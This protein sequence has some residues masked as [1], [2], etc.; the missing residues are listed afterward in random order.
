MK[1]LSKLNLDNLKQNRTRTIVTILGVAMSIM[2][3]LT[4]IGI[5][6][7][8]WFTEYDSIR[9]EYGDYHVMFENIP[10]DKVSIL[11]NSKFFNVE[12]YSEPVEAVI[13]KDGERYLYWYG[14]YPVS[15]YTKITADELK[16]DRNHSYNVFL[17]YKDF[18]NTQF[19]DKMQKRALEEADV[20]DVYVRYNSDLQMLEG[21]IPRTSRIA[22]AAFTTLVLGVMVIAA[23]FVIRNSFNISITERVRQ[24]GMLSSVGARPRQIRRMVYMESA[25]IGLIALPIGIGLG[26]LLTFGVVVLFNTLL[27]DIMDA[28]GMELVFFIPWQAIII[29]LIVTAVLIFLSA[30]SPA[31]VAGRYSPL[32]ALRSNQDIKI[33]AR[34][35]RTSKLTRKIWGIGGVIARKNLKRSRQKYRTTV[36]SIV[37]SVSVFIG[38][39]SFM[40]YSH[41]VINL[42][43]NDNGS[44]F[45]IYGN[46]NSVDTNEIASNFNLKEYAAYHYISFETIGDDNRMH[47]SFTVVSRD[48][49]ARYAKK[50][51]AGGSDYSRMVILHD[52]RKIY[53]SDGSISS[54]RSTDYKVGD[55]V[56]IRSVSYNLDEE[57]KTIRELIEDGELDMDDLYDKDAEMTEEE[58]AERLDDT[59]RV[60]G[61]KKY[62]DADLTF[63][64]ITEKAPLG[65]N[66][67]SYS[68]GEVF[69]SED[70]YQINKIYTTDY[71]TMFIAD[72]GVGSDIAEFLDSEEIVKKYG[73][74]SYE[75]YEELMRVIRNTILLIEILIYGFIVI[76][77]LIGV[78]N[79]FNT[80][81]T[82]VALR[83]RE[84]AIIKSVGMTSKEFNHMI[85]LE[86]VMYSARALLIGLPIGLLISYGTFKLFDAAGLEFG[87]IIPWNAIIISVASVGLLVAAIM[88]YSVRKI[89]RQNII[90]TIRSESF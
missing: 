30:V 87:W 85:R 11:E 22:L 24:F 52:N 70:Y 9:K 53:H 31:I 50:I 21:G 89:K 46:S 55:T 81:T 59:I 4:T 7:S 12:Y 73:I 62:K 82:N 5:A 78:T 15:S 90:E 27:S 29:I 63:T 8:F 67:S 6:T 77:S 71:Y 79:I 48:E 64:H 19:A 26:C 83:A 45:V 38:V 2:L 37:L 57:D 16:R 28:I 49:F 42:F 44:N 18:E 76:V 3:I 40:N 54:G 74:T 23:A 32:S 84:F 72:S 1:I 34:K 43:I 20:E 69:I 35:V 51:G 75:N 36:V 41:R 86:S 56:H 68:I 47:L 10:G 13:D 58:L 33:K 65:Y 80:I 39:M 17:K 25:I 61:N 66:E 60:Y 88:R 14:P